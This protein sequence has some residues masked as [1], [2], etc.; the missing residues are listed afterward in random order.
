MYPYCLYYLGMKIVKIKGHKFTL[1]QVKA[2]H[3]F[4]TIYLIRE[5]YALDDYDFQIIE[6]VA[7]FGTDNSYQDGWYYLPKEILA[8]SV[9]LSRSNVIVHLNRLI[10]KKFLYRNIY[11]EQMLKVN[12]GWYYSTLKKY[13]RIAH[14]KIADEELSPM[15]KGL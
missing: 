3:A 13:K 1:D 12:E 15:E 4:Y 7:A 9:G 11:V 8:G 10:K 14:D 6:T 5:A 2:S